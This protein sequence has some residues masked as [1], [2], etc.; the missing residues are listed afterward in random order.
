MGQQS[1]DLSIVDAIA[2]FLGHRELKDVSTATLDI[3]RHWLTVWV[4]WRTARDLP[5]QVPAIHVDDL[6]AFFH[7][8]A[9]DHIPHER[10][11]KRPSAKTRGLAPASS[12]GCWRVLR[13]L[14]RYLADEGKLSGDQV[15]F[16]T[17]SRIPCPRVPE[18][19]REACSRD[20]LDTLLVACGDAVDE[21]SA[22]NRVILLLLYESG[23]RVSELCRL[24]DH[25]IRIGQDTALV[26]GKGRKQRWVYW[27][28]RST[29][30]LLRYLRVRRGPIGGPLIRG[31]SS[32]NS[33]K[34]MTRDAVRARLKRLAKQAGVKLPAE[35][36]VHF[37]RHGFAH[38][39]LDAGLD[40]SQLAQLLGH[41]DIDTTM[42]YVREHP[43]R[44][45]EIHARIFGTKQNGAF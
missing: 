20:T 30:A 10:N 28:P 31:V 19:V 37:L 27:G 38:A 6:R 13:A 25:E 36:P 17:G 32:R 44:L 33:G 14:W 1:I 29:E 21:E 8:L 43:R 40:V 2:S 3:Y 15:R 9:K 12:A 34:A 24:C 26:H 39:A 18:Q 41:A 22:R 4:T 5:L 42:R 7:Y 23:M 11:P 35:A 16:F 45:R